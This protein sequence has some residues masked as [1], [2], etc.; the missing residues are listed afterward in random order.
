MYTTVKEN[1][2]HQSIQIRPAAMQDLHGVVDLLNTC[3]LE[4]VGEAHLEAGLIRAEWESPGRDLAENSRVAVTPN[5][6]V[7]GYIEIWDQD[8]HVR[9]H[10]YGRVHPDHRGQGIGSTLV[11]W[12]ETR[13]RQAIPKAPPGARVIMGQ[14]TPSDDTKTQA[15]FEGDDYRAMRASYQMK[16]EMDSPPPSPVLPPGI[17]IRPYLVGQEEEAVLITDRESFRDHWGYVVRPLEQ[18]RERFLHWMAKDPRFDPTLWF[19]AVEG[20]QIVGLS[21][22]NLKTAGVPEVGWVDSLGVLR[23]WRRQGIGLALLLHSFGEF[24]H[25]GTYRVELGVDAESLTGATRLYE[26]AGMRVKNSFVYYEKELRPGFDPSTQSV[27][28]L[29]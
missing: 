18:D 6:R 17:S 23:P 9:V 11:R 27:T 29:D 10:V 26:K 1:T 5:G 28:D 25:R 19:V 14:E 7:V 3:L 16:I 13:A 4:Q 8:P 24:Y 12:A 21:L 2:N 22:C 20:D 15:L